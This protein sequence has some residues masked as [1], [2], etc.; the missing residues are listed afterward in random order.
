MNERTFKLALSSEANI[1]EQKY[2]QND[3]IQINRPPG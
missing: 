2:A 3:L 1:E